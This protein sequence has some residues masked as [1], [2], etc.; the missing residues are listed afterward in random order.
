MAI[1]NFSANSVEDCKYLAEDERCIL[2]IRALT[3]S[4]KEEVLEHAI[5]TIYNL[6]TIE[7]CKQ[8]AVKYGVIKTIFELASS[9]FVSVRHVCSSCLH[10]AP[11]AIPDMR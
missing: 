9:G 3:K 7:S 1:R 8:L 4:M 10:M 5:G 2:I 6:M 11:E